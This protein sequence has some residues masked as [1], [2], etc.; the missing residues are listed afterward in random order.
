[1]GWAVTVHDFT[2]LKLNLFI[3]NM[4]RFILC[5][6]FHVSHPGLQG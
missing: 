1:M 2:F 6:R 4:S 5:V 3:P